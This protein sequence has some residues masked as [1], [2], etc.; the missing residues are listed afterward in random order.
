[1]K[2][3]AVNG[4]P[5][6]DYNTATLLKYALKGAKAKGA[7]TELIHL[8]DYDYKGCQSCF[9]CKKKNTKTNGLCVIKDSLSNLLDKINEAD[10]FIIGAPIY[11]GSANSMTGAFFERLIFPY[12]TYG[13]PVAEQR[14]K[15]TGFIYTLG[16]DEE[17]MKTAGFDHSAH[18]NQELLMRIFGSSEYLLVNDTYQ[19]DDYSKYETTSINMEVKTKRRNEVF[20]KD[21]DSAYELGA[22]L[23]D[24]PND[25]RIN[26]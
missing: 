10:A 9:S 13:R 5:R 18:W 12:I 11:L 17:R 21:C 16:A 24:I 25:F 2:L 14:Q 4:S 22:R 20:P 26:R 8:Y 1:M 15:K 23:V 7:E 3:I 19:F 6:K